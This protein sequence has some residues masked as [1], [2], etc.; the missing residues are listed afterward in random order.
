MKEELFDEL[1][2]SAHEGG[3]ILRAEKSPSRKFTF[4]SMNNGESVS[5]GQ[6]TTR[7]MLKLWVITDKQRKNDE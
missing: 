1:L 6:G 7:Q 3:V 2:E 5:H 4:V